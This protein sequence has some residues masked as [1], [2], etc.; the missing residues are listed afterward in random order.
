MGGNTLRHGTTVTLELVNTNG[1]RVC[2]EKNVYGTL[3][4]NPTIDGSG[5]AH[6]WC[7][8]GLNSGSA[9][10]LCLEGYP[11]RDEHGYL[12][13]DDLRNALG[14]L[15]SL[16]TIILS[17]TAVAQ[18][19]LA[20]DTHPDLDIGPWYSA[21][22]VHTLVIHSNF[23]HGI[24]PDTLQVLLTVAQ[25]RKAAGYPFRSVSLFLLED[26]QS[27]RV[28]D[29]LRECI[30]GFEVTV[31]DGVLGWDVDRHFLAGLDHLRKRLDVWCDQMDDSLRDRPKTRG[32]GHLS[33]AIED[34]MVY[35]YI[36]N[37]RAYTRPDDRI[38]ILPRLQGF[39]GL[40]KSYASPPY[41]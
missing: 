27:G 41:Y 35:I 26:P 39:A 17:F 14:R 7:L 9:E 31:G 23:Y 8:Y 18:C 34:E 38:G 37:A 24:W 13:T 3:V 40:P 32:R 16:T 1:V 28:L 10:I 25:R 2:S 22:S 20:L 36:S 19:L 15:P 29:Q 5:L 12:A 6:L 30:E 11:M 33:G 4:D 21:P